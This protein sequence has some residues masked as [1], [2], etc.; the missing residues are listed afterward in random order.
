MSPSVKT[1]KAPFAAI[2]TCPACHS[3]KYL[4]LRCF[5]V[6]CACGWDSSEA[7]VESGAMD[8]LMAAW[9]RLEVQ[10]LKTLRQRRRRGEGSKA[11][12]LNAG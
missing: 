9:E 7:F 10:R 5:D 12:S 8:I 3:G 4:R 6:V 11:A 1:I 2:K